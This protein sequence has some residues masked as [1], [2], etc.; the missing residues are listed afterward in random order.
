MIKAMELANGRRYVFHEWG[1]MVFQKR[2]GGVGGKEIQK[3]FFTNLGF[4]P[5]VTTLADHSPGYKIE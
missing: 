1:Q 5:L 3:Y 2:A 4:K